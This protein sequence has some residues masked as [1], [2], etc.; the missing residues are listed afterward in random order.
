M[1]IFPNTLD[2]SP[3]ARGFSIE[4]QDDINVVTTFTAG[5]I[6]QRPTQIPQTE[7]L[8][9]KWIY[10]DDEF[11]VFWDFYRNTLLNGTLWFGIEFDF[12]SNRATTSAQFLKLQKPQRLE[13]FNGFEITWQM[14]VRWRLITNFDDT[15][16]EFVKEFGFA[17]LQEVIDKMNEANIVMQ[18]ANNDIAPLWDSL[19]RYNAS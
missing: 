19:E 7:I 18:R 15:A 16:T 5:N 6:R 17:N 2:S 3:L 11:E 8:E 4:P 9:G 12:T 14:E 10:T 13:R 1:I